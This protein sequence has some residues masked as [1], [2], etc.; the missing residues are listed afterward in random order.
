MRTAVTRLIVIVVI[1][2]VGSVLLGSGCFWEPK[3]RVN[4]LDSRNPYT[5]SRPKLEAML[6]DTVTDTGPAT[7][8]RLEWDRIDHWHVTG[9]NLFRYMK[10]DTS[11]TGHHIFF[12]IASEDDS[13]SSFTDTLADPFY[14]HFYFMTAVLDD[15][16]DSLFSDTVRN[17]STIDTVSQ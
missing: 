14:R 5:N 17:P 2:G 15:G 12:C 8:V 16:Y 7:M 3:E 11:D 6:I 13:V 1:L 10:L 9:Y 4:P